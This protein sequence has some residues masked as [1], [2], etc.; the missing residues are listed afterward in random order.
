MKI[1]LKLIDKIKD[2]Y[3][4]RYIQLT[5]NSIKI[6][7]TK[8]INLSIMLTLITGTTWYGK[9]DFYPKSKFYFKEFNNNLK[10]I[11]NT[12]LKEVPQLKK[13]IIKAHQK[14]KSCLDLQK[15][16]RNY[17]KALEDKALLKEY[18]EYFLSNYDKF[19]DIFYYFYE[20]IH[21]LLNLTSMNGQ[22]FIKLL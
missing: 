2:K 19:C 11:K 13:M 9:Y 17:E 1:A 16:L 10:I 12:K 21:K 15:I 3:R 6:C 18:L 7:N 20:D 5:D 14:S 22:V 8:K 4:L